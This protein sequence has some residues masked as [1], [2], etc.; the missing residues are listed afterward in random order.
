[1]QILINPMDSLSQV[2]QKYCRYCRSM[3]Y[4]IVLHCNPSTLLSGMRNQSFEGLC[5]STFSSCPQCFSG[6]HANL[7]SQLDEEKQWQRLWCSIAYQP[8][9][10]ITEMPTSGV[11]KSGVFSRGREGGLWPLIDITNGPGPV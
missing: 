5:P 3:F 4:N 7:Y 10:H 6:T 1:M 11:P 8:Y 9:D 2:A